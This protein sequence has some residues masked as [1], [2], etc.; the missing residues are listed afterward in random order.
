MNCYS[1]VS[2]VV[3]C[4]ALGGL[5][6][7][8][9]GPLM[10]Q[11]IAQQRDDSDET[12]RPRGE[13]RG[14]WRRFRREGA[15]QEERE[16]FLQ[17]MRERGRGGRDRDQSDADPDNADRRNGDNDDEQDRGRG[18]RNRGDRGRN[19]DDDANDEEANGDEENRDGEDRGFGGRRRGGR[20]GFDPEDFA[21]MRFSQLD[22]NGNDRLEGEELEGL[23]GPLAEADLNGDKVVTLDEVVERISNLRNSRGEEN[24]DQGQ[25]NGAAGSGTP[26]AAAEKPKAQRVYLGSAAGAPPKEGEEANARR[27]Y[28]FTPARESLPAGLPT[29][30]RMRDR[31]GDGQVSMNEYSRVWSRRM[32]NEYLDNDLN[33]DGVIT[34]K[35]AQAA[36]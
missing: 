9:A 19:D 34:P 1:R 22:A 36:E 23:R 7:L 12:D 13:F 11:A 4:W 28:R 15:S 14:G 21:R 35:E 20:R 26:A 8:E 18:D 29:W 3:L 30:F 16:R 27:T 32:V 2:W 33:E 31:N 6:G 5:F 24:D 17:M 25:Q 10:P